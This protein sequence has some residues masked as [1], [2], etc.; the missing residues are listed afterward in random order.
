MNQQTQELLDLIQALVIS[1]QDGAIDAGD[2]AE[3]CKAASELLLSLRAVL[4]RWWQRA[5]AQACANALLE[6]AIY[7]QSLERA[8]ENPERTR[9]GP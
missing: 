1:I 3:L 8:A 2:G 5:T 6:A 4:P 7:L 9:V